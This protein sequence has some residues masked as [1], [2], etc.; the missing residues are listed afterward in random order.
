VVGADE[1]DAERGVASED[2]VKRH[3]GQPTINK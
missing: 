3:D 1:D 2:N